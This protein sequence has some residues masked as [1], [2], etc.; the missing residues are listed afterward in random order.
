MSETRR[1]FT[2]QRY[3]PELIYSELLFHVEDEDSLM[4]ALASS[5]MFIAWQKTAG[6]RLKSG[7]RCS[8]TL[9][10]NTFPVPELDDDTRTKI[11][12]A[13]KKALEACEPHPEGKR[14]LANHYNPLAMDP[15]LLKAH[16]VLDRV[17]D[18]AMGTPKKLTTEKQRQE[19]LLANYARMM[20][21]YA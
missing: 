13:G 10:W 17:V 21:E 7:L 9:V 8:N 18:K 12:E 5:L 15:A 3:G 19:I 1:Y 2:V 14:S 20:S 11:I 6:G 16:D 4:F